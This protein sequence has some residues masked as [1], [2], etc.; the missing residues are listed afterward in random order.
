[1]NG[2]EV[3][4]AQPRVEN[5]T[6]LR[7]GGDRC[8]RT[9]NGRIRYRYPRSR[10]LVESEGAEAAILQRP[11]EVR[12]SLARHHRPLSA[13][14]IAGPRRRREARVLVDGCHARRVFHRH[15]AGLDERAVLERHV[16]TQQPREAVGVAVFAAQRTRR[17]A[18]PAVGDCHAA[19]VVLVVD[20]LGEARR[21]AVVVHAAALAGDDL[22]RRVAVAH[23]GLVVTQRYLVR[24]SARVVRAVH[25]ARREALAHRRSAP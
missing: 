11:R 12:R 21:V 1:M 2:G 4:R 19:F 16:A 13:D 7:V 17:A 25:D 6:V 10:R 9:R 22:R 23:R 24:E 3:S 15:L 20:A 14:V 18:E 5:E 8:L